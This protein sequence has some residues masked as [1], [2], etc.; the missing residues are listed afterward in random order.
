MNKT[1]ISLGILI[2]ASLTLT[3]YF[4][5][6]PNGANIKSDLDQNPTQPTM[7][8]PIPTNMPPSVPVS[9]IPTQTDEQLLNGLN[10][11]KNINL[12]SQFLQLENELK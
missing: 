8:T 12:D 3:A 2:F 4:L 5:L 9:P 10:Q 1:I 11:D 6:F 7:I